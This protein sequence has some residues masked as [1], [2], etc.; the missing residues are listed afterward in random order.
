MRNRYLVRVWWAALIAGA[1]ACGGGPPSD[2][3]S[4]PRSGAAPPQSDWSIQI[5][6]LA[7]PASGGSAQ[8]QLTSSSR[9]LILSW[10]EQ[11]G[12]TATLKFAE[13]T[14]AGWSQARTV[15]SGDDWFLS[16]ADVP[17][18]VRLSNGTLVASWYP[19][20]DP[21]IEAY[22]IRLSYSRDD[23]TTWAR[24]FTPHH[25]GTKTQHGFVSLFE[26]PDAT[27]GLVWLD[28]R[29][30]ELKSAE[31][32]GA[33]MGL[34][35]AR[36]DAEW[37]QTAE[38]PVNARVCECCPTA[39]A[40][41]DDGVVTAFRDRSPREIRDI[42]LTRLENG[43]WTPARPIHVDGWEIEACPVNGPALSARGRQVA[44]AWFTAA[45]NQG[46]TLAAFSSDAGRTWGDPIRL[47]DGAPR[48][49]V[50]IELLDDGSA[51]ATWV[52]LA[53]ERSR[54]RMRRVE[55][56]GA[57]SAAFDVA[58]E[59]VTG[60]PRIARSADE[61]VFAWT[62]SAAEGEGGEQ[63]KGAVARLPRTTAP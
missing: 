63:I 21:F 44:A 14:A 42:N 40:V 7:L 35:F 54:F 26:L 62:E 24:P 57:R 34:Y 46:Q 31:P 38:S 33:D 49:H 32:A 51:V 13:R 12:A 58:A 10:L 22:D 15:T 11:T 17:S 30:Q 27:L 39:T 61:L 29:D 25:D 9:S 43:S 45:G 19:A 1:V 23:G 16:W 52:E 53:D 41:T 8:P 20:T 55:P 48:G 4:E 5:E 50:D 3:R 60:Y 6:P 36:Y 47:D 18:V 28:G 37:K 59:R 2:E 56:S